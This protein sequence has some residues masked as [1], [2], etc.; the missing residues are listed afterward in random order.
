MRAHQGEVAQI[1]LSWEFIYSKESNSFQQDITRKKKERSRCHNVKERA[2][3]SGETQERRPKKSHLWGNEKKKEC[4][5]GLTQI[6]AKVIQVLKWGFEK[7]VTDILFFC[8]PPLEFP[9]LRLLPVILVI[10]TLAGDNWCLDRSSLQGWWKNTCLNTTG[11]P[12]I[13]P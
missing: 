10:L 4:W 12:P 1:D 7:Q 9:I 6:K 13:F 5:N 8:F 3:R 2:G 11:W